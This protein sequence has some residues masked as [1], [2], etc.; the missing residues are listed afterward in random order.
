MPDALAQGRAAVRAGLW[1]DAFD[2][3]TVADGFA[4]LDPDDLEALGWA[5]VFSARPEAAVGARQ[6]AF[7]ALRSTEPRRAA[8]IAIHIGLG[9][10]ARGALAVGLGW[11]QQAADLLAGQ[12]ECEESAWLAWLEAVVASESGQGEIALAAADDVIARAHRL[13]VT[14]VEALATLLKG[15][16]L[17]S[18]GHAEEGARFI[19]PVM[20]LAVGGVLGQFAAAYVYCGTISTCASTGDLQRA[21]EWTN[22]VGRCGVSGAAD[23]PGDCRMHRAELLR[24]RGDWAKAEVEMASVCDDL[25]A[26]HPGHVAIAHYELGELSLLRG[27]LP[28]AAEAFAHCREL[29]HSPLP[30]MASLELAR[31]NPQAAMALVCGELATTNGPLERSRLLPVAIDSMLASDRIDD[32]RDAARELKTLAASWSASLQQARAAHAEGAVALAAGD[33][34][35]ARRCL[36]EAV[37]LWRKVPAPYEEARARELLGLAEEAG[38][39]VMHFEAALETFARL[40]AVPDAQRVTVHLGRHPQVDR[41]ALALMFTDIEG[42]SKMLAELGDEAWLKVLRRH[43]NTLRELFGRYRGEELT[44]TGDGFFVGFPTADSALDCA[45]DIQRTVE[46]VRVRV[47]VHFTEA[48]RDQ[49]GLSGRGVHEAARISAIGSGGDVV[50]STATLERAT[51]RYPTRETRTVGLKGLPGEM[52]I[53]Y[54]AHGET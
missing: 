16:I 37:E 4:P 8:L 40:G 50:V 44:G 29:G 28:G 22:E 31:G 39:R 45:L 46:Q 6:R 49:S 52:Q 35:D 32:A 38:A 54:L 20:A 12:G 1:S 47:G 2:A 34:L 48:S 41:V 43:D 36:R 21:W 42:S 19:D 5:A 27:D 11:V 18:Q 30:G 9:H 51:K 10:L 53:A 7:A 24:V 26:W 33:V 13:G 25:D 14:D 17:T 23:F 15:Q 3:L